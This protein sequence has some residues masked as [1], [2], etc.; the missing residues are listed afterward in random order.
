[1]D[2]RSFLGVSVA[3]TVGSLL[4]FGRAFA[5]GAQAPGEVRAITLDGTPAALSNSDLQQLKGNLRGNLI[6]PGHAA[7]EDARRLRNPSLDS[8]RR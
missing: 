5:D 3:A 4:P 7:Y 1:M 6:L 2:R 8:T